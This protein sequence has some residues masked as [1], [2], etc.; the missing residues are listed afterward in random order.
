MQNFLE[1]D[2]QDLPDP[3]TQEVDVAESPF[4]EEPNVLAEAVVDDGDDSAAPAGSADFPRI[5]PPVAR[6]G[7]REPSFQS[8]NS[9]LNP[10]PQRFASV[11]T[12]PGFSKLQDTP[13]TASTTGASRADPKVLER[14]PILGDDPARIDQLSRRP[15]AEVLAAQIEEATL[16]SA[17]AVE[18]DVSAP[19]FMVHL[20][21]S[22]GSGKTSV[23]NFLRAHLQDR[24]RARAEQWVV[25]DFNAWQQ[26]RIQP[27][28]WALIT[29]IYSQGRTQLDR[30]HS[31]LFWQRWLLWRARADWVPS[32]TAALFLAVAVLLGVQAI[33][34]VPQTAVASKIPSA[35]S[36]TPYGAL[37][38]TVEL[39]LKVVVALSAA[40]AALFTFTKSLMFGSARAAQTYA[41]MRTD[42]LRPIVR[43]F[44]RLVK[45]IRRPVLVV[46]DDLD[47]CESKYVVEFL[48]G[49]QV[50][51]RSAPVTY[52]VAADRKW[53]CSSFEKVYG[54]FGKTVAEPGRPLGYLFLDKL[55]QLGAQVPRLTW[56][57]QQR[58]WRA[59]LHPASRA[60]LEASDEK[61]RH[62]EREA[63][64]DI[65]NL[66]TYEDLQ[67]RIDQTSGDAERE[68]AMRAAAA[69]Q[70]TAAR[71]LM[72]TE[73]RLQA[74]A[75]LL[76]PNPR[77]MKRLVNAYG[78][79]QATHF[80]E[81]RKVSPD[82]LALWTI[83][84]LRWPL[85]A[86]FLTSYPHYAAQLAREHAVEDAVIPDDLKALFADEAVQL[87]FGGSTYRSLN[88][89]RIRDVVGLPPRS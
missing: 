16:Q 86:D 24:K 6:A 3:D 31:L 56:D 58:Y 47:R 26:Q 10:P 69:K 15:F 21:G 53:I 19:A 89:K 80:L 66:H 46:V 57:L 5:P 39:S 18:E 81:G 43:L 35:S 75:D 85:L 30:F 63:L 72:E 45:A 34:L 40:G 22:W 70:I 1:S 27:P 48:E 71:A 51:F 2:M 67:L 33:S 54:E 79:H 32:V 55:F 83:V 76:E 52:V 77:S 17:G 8:S 78:L 49:I 13:P 23:L 82:A 44:Q 20:H 88:E 29:A 65:A 74:F 62:N 38:S 9:P 64:Q 41:A 42:P 84:E 73:H 37:A 4:D 59:L 14:V 7:I 11:S 36:G 28:W 25:I 61:R 68:Q 12:T 50:L 87:I 60:E